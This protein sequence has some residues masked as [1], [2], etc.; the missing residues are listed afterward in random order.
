MSD[1]FD[2]KPEHK[3]TFGLWTVGNAGRDPFGEAVREPLSPAEIVHLLAEVGAYGVNFHDNDLVPIDA[4]AS[5]ARPDREGLQDRRWTTPAWSCRWRPPTSSPTRPSRTARS[6]QRPAGP[7]LRPAED[8]ARHRPGGRAGREGLRLLGRPRGHRDRRRQETRSTPRSASARRSTSCATTDRTRA[9]TSSSRWR[10]SPTS[11]AATSTCPTS[12]SMLGFI[13]TLDH[14]DM[15]GVNPEFAHE[16]MAGL[17]FMHAVAQALGRGQA[18]PYRPQR[19]EVR[20]ATT[21]TCASARR[22]SSRP[23]SWSSSWRTC[24]YDGPRHFDAHALPHRGHEGVKDFAR[25]CMRTYLILKEKAAQFNA[26]PGDPGLLAEIN[27][28]DGTTDPFK[29]AYSADKA[30]ALK[31]HTFDREALAARGMQYEKLDQL[32]VELLL[33]VR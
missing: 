2:P 20:R 24:G 29:G 27:A 19:P 14:P 7:R 9:T 4:T 31:A 1:R 6:R 21:R 16:H 12:A 3:F 10:P 23:S 15:V 33:G 32:T 13:Q 28:D 11:P 25:G 30:A 18:V 26:D 17:N 8:D 22:T 5:R